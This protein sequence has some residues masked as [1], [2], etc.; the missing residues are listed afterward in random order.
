MSFRIF[1]FVQFAYIGYPIVHL[2]VIFHVQVFIALDQIL[3]VRKSINI[4][5]YANLN[6]YRRSFEFI[7]VLQGSHVG[8]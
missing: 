5:I 8:N 2:Y 4:A 6:F 7:F 1:W 3:T